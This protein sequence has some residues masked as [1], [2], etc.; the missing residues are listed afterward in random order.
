MAPEFVASFPAF[1]PMES[2]ASEDP[3]PTASGALGPDGRALVAA[4]YW[5]LLGALALRRVTRRA[6][7]PVPTSSWEFGTAPPVPRY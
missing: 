6:E 7:E 3:R 5:A 2:T 4:A 1:L